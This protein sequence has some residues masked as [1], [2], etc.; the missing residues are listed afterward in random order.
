MLR[1][2]ALKNQVCETSGK[3]CYRRKIGVTK[4]AEYNTQQKW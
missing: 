2:A 4:A 3:P 1:Y